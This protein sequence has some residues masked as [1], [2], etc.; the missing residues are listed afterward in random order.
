[1]T[2]AELICPACGHRF[3]VVLTDGEHGR[4]DPA[5]GFRCPLCASPASICDAPECRPPTPE[6]FTLPNLEREDW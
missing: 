5:L 6:K 3:T 1:M 2:A 4:P